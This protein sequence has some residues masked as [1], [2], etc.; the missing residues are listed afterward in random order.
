MEN[1]ISFETWLCT[2]VSTGSVSALKH[3]GIYITNNGL[4]CTDSQKSVRSQEEKVD[5]SVMSRTYSLD[6]CITFGLPRS[7]IKNNRL[8]MHGKP[9]IRKSTRRKQKHVTCIHRYRH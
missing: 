9:I 2:Q 1:N 5:D 4:K 8:K 6:Y 3:Y 7:F